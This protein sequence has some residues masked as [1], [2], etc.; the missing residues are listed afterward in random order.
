MLSPGWYFIC[1]FVLLGYFIYHKKYKAVISS[2]VFWLTFLTVLLG[3]VALVRY[4][5][6]FFMGIPQLIALSLVETE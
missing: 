6:I 1:A 4:V 5:L 3:P 2:L